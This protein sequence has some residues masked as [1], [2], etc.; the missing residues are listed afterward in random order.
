M[1]C[2]ACWAVPG[3]LGCCTSSST[4]STSPTPSPYS[5][6]YK[7]YYHYLT[8]TFTIPTQLFNSVYYL[9][10]HLHHTQLFTWYTT[11]Y[12]TYTF[13]ILNSLQ[14]ILPSTSTTPSPYSTRYKVYYH[15]PCPTTPSPYSTRY[16]VYYHLPQL[17]LYHTQL[18]ARYTTIYLTYTF[19]IN[20]S[21]LGILPSNPPT[22]SP[23]STRFKI[24]YH[25]PQLHLHHTQLFT[26]YTKIYSTYTFNSLY[27]SLY[28]V[29]YH[30]PHLHLHHTQL[31]TWYTTNYLIYTFTMLNSLQG[32][33][34]E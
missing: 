9:Y 18:F 19:T 17:H 11:I 32:F 3:S 20:N 34:I 1:C 13:T 7:V 8:Y 2:C 25:L 29:Y 21:L 30:L 31:F 5:T 27:S 14:S 15:L 12:L 26:W 24:Y 16:K 22:P 4:A 10:L 6:L 28:M 23:Y 33:I